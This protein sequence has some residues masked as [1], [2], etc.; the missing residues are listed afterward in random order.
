MPTNQESVYR[1]KSGL[2]LNYEKR[3]EIGEK[4]SRKRTLL[5][6]G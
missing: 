2:E 4:V 5:G 6:I 3:S 1:R